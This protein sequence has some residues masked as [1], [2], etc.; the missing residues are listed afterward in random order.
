MLRAAQ[1]GGYA[2]GAFNVENMEMMQAV[3]AAAVQMRAPVILQTT[4]GTL[5]YAPPELFAAMAGALMAQVGVPALL[6][7]DHGNSFELA[8]RAKRAGY[9][10]LMIDGSKLPYEE[11]VELTGRVVRMAGTL[12]V[13]AELGTVGGKEDGHQAQVQ[14]TDPEQAADFAARTG[15]GSFAVAI[16]TAHGF[17]KGE[18]KL[19]LDRLSLI[20][21]R[22]D[23]PLVL[24]GTSGVSGEQV[25]ACVR[26]GIC[27]VN[28]ATDL[29][30]AYTAG[31]R[32]ALV[33]KPDAVDPKLFGKAGRE[34][35]QRRVCELM[36]LCGCA[37]KA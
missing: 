3:L 27:K 36:E 34:A 28:Y 8:E 20:R 14:Y 19:D 4:P 2:V 11:N 18:P 30:V 15:I 35:V 24:H 33:Q 25:R 12:P 5:G 26:R 21:Q 13:E 9:G 32:A 1:R 23:I 31:V 16:G 29:R 6:H 17:Y 7:L 10:S 22:V 37:G